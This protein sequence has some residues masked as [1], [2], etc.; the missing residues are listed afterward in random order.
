MKRRTT[1][2]RVR[3]RRIPAT[4]IC[5]LTV[6][7]FI[8]ACS[9]LQTQKPVTELASLQNQRSVSERLALQEMEEIDTLIKLDNRWLAK[10]FEDVIQARA[11]SIDTHDFRKI[12]TYF[13]NNYIELEIVSNI[14]DEY[15]N[16][17]NA[18]LWGDILL[19][20]RGHG[21]E[22]QP[23]FSQVQITSKDFTFNNIIHVLDIRII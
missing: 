12:K 9:V 23:R 5:L 18:K 6:L 8:A 16:T 15:G 10:Q 4:L 11:S 3:F 21:L 17:I 22:W 14:K 2:T 1:D 7:Q 20:Y 13:I 19:K